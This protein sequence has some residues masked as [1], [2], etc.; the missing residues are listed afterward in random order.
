MDSLTH[1]NAFISERLTAAAVEI[2]GAVEKTL[3]EY[4]REM[5]RSKDEIDHL[6]SLVL[7]PEV[8]LHRSAAHQLSPLGC[9]QEAATE[10]CHDKRQAPGVSPGNRVTLHV[11]EEHDQRT[12]QQ[13]GTAVSPQIVKRA[14]KDLS[15]H[16]YRI[17]H[18]EQ[19][20]DIK[21]EPDSDEFITSPSRREAELHCGISAE[22]CGLQ[23]EAL[24]DPLEIADHAQDWSDEQ[25]YPEHDWSP[26]PEDE[27]SNPR[28]IK[29][30]KFTSPSPR[31]ETEHEYEF[32]L[33]LEKSVYNAPH[34]SCHDQTGRTQTLHATEEERCDEGGGSKLSRLTGVPQPFYCVDPDSHDEN[35]ECVMN[36]ESIRVNLLTGARRKKR[37]TPNLCYKEINSISVEEDVNDLTRERRHTCPMCA[38]RF[39]ESS[40]LKEHVRIH[41]G[42]KPYQCKQCGMNFRQS[43]ALTLHMRIHTGERPYQ[44]NDCGR[45]FNRK[46]DMESHMVTHTGERPHMCTVCGKSYRRK[47]NLNT[48]LKVHAESKRDYTQPL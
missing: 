37:K 4:Q 46:G 31:E 38:K 8:R 11:K 14:H 16:L 9:D 42:E 35:A 2:F 21:S 25:Q 43:G 12:D 47:S 10:C 45:R 39:K 29:V 27:E 28:P 7:W 41:T 17:L 1:L 22:S 34:S 5:S 32:P 40:H 19:T 13:R 26:C 18:V 23:Q 20:A 15:R 36:G 30:E 24:T 6:R 44:C 33:K 3:V 48:H